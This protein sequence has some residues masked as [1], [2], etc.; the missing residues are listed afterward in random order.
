MAPAG[1]IYE[2][3]LKN[4]MSG[5]PKLI[6]KITKTCSEEEKKG[7]D[8]L[9]TNPFVMIR[10]AGSLGVDLVALRWDCSFPIEVKSSIDETLHFS[11]NPRLMEQ[12]TKMKE[13]CQTAHLLPVYAFRL[14][15]CKGDPWRIFALPTEELKGNM[16]LVQGQVP[17]IEYNDK[18]HY[19][20]KWC[21]G[22]KLSD[23]VRYLNLQG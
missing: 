4:L 6:D 8:S 13:E 14:K 9:K 22:I 5:D 21:K 17:K 2:R 20:M 16:R 12:A 23:F 1:N 11:R 3:E 7:Y 15:R 10:A 19:I 18:N